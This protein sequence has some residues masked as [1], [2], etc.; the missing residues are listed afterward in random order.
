MPVLAPTREEFLQHMMNKSALSLSSINLLLTQSFEMEGASKNSSS[1]VLTNLQRLGK[2]VAS[3]KMVNDGNGWNADC[4]WDG[5]VGSRDR[6]WLTSN[7]YHD[8]ET[9][10]SPLHATTYSHMREEIRKMLEIYEQ[11]T[12]GLAHSVYASNHVHNTIAYTMVESMTADE[13]VAVSTLPAYLVYRYIGLF[14]VKFYPVLKWLC[15]TTPEGARGA[16]KYGN[17]YDC[18]DNDQIWEW[19]FRYRLHEGLDKHRRGDDG[20]SSDYF[21]RRMERSSS[22]R[23]YDRQ[24]ACHWENRMCDNTASHTHLSAWLA[25]NRAITL[26]AVDFGRNFYAFNVTHD[27]AQKSKQETRNHRR[28][29]LH[30]DRPYIEQ[31]WALMKSYLMKYLKIAGCLDAVKQLD[32]LIECP[33]PQY[34]ASPKTPY[35]E[36]YNPFHVERAFRLRN[37]ERDDELRTRYMNAIKAM[38]IPMA[39]KLDDFH[40]NVAKFLGIEYREAKSLYQM[41]N[42]EKVEIEFLGNRLVY[43]GD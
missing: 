38:T 34:L 37:R 11:A 32:K 19:F 18:L 15:M 25:I 21:L 42:R 33:V 43:M 6:H 16:D 1:V 27:E 26:W 8:V 14:F 2:G 41:L 17:N 3:S 4:H 12:G 31:R 20:G 10:S 30:V 22:F 39:D 23:I 40:H 13:V 28:G 35:K 29:W 9:S 5:T 24:K 7:G 36:H